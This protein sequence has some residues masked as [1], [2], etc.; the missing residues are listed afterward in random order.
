MVTVDLLPKR[1]LGKF[2]IVLGQAQPAQ[3]R[4]EAEALQQ[5]LLNQKA[6]VRGQR[7]IQQLKRT[8]HRLARLVQIEFK[9]SAGRKGLLVG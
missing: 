1:D 6:I 8:V 2:A 7:R 3:I 9:I 5:L 4:R